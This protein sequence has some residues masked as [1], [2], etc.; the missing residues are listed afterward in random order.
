[1]G[2]EKIQDKS[3]SGEMAIIAKGK[4]ARELGKHPA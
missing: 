3:D 1:M 2:G 4:Q